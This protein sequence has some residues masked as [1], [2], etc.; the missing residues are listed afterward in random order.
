MSSFPMS[1]GTRSSVRSSPPACRGGE[2][3]EGGRMLGVV[4]PVPPGDLC[5]AARLRHLAPA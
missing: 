5:K 1:V 4:L 3:A 2:L